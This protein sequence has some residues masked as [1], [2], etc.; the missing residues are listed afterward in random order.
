MLRLVARRGDRLA[1]AGALA[2]L[3][4]LAACSEV[5]FAAQTAKDFSGSES[6]QIGLYKVG[7]PYQ[8]G[9]K[10]YYP[11]VDLSYDETGIAS[12]Y[13]PGFHGKTTANGERYDQNDLTAAHPTLPMPSLVEVTNLENGRVLRV[14]INDRGPYKNG[15][16]I[17]L[18]KRAAELLQVTRAGTAK[19]R[20][21]VLP[22]ESL[23]LAA[24]AQGGSPEQ[25]AR[26][27]APPAVPVG[28]VSA[29]PLPGTPPAPRAQR[30]PAQ[31]AVAQPAVARVPAPRELSEAS[32]PDGR[33]GQVA[34]A[35]SA[36][37]IQAGAFTEPL[38]A[39]QLAGRLD[40]LGPV[41]VAPA[42]VNGMQFY[43]VQLGPLG[44]VGEADV[45]LSQLLD[46]GFAEAQVVVR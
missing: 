3:L 5:Q 26:A 12:W 1:V 15:R 28:S 8:I 31:V 37:F 4:M 19:V 14:R 13:G 7:N 34:I 22:D 39:H 23:Q 46:Y 10:W 36:I 20:V 17:D 38:N 42:N 45:L 2:G 9:G 40:P 25:L 11:K 35:P 16:I 18:S 43:R 41:S 44:S 30:Q 24:V 32:L 33:V 21:R 6:S 27:S 29:E